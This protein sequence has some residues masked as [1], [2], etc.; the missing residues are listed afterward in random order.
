MKYLAFTILNYT[1][2]ISLENV[3]YGKKTYPI[4]FIC[5]KNFINSFI[6]LVL[7]VTF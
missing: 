6:E 5:N 3:S 4:V 7:E 1:F 2:L